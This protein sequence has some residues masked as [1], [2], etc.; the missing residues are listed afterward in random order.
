M[1]IHYPISLETLRN[2]VQAIK[3]Q[4]FAMSHLFVHTQGYQNTHHNRS[5]VHVIIFKCHELHHLIREITLS[6]NQFRSIL[7]FSREND[8]FMFDLALI[9]NKIIWSTF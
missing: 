1:K 2:I 3:N 6:A 9:Q 8:T 5:D 7:Q 4:T